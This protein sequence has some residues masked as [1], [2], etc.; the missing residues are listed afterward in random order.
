MLE[1]MFL[2]ALPSV[3]LAASQHESM[4]P[5]SGTVSDGFAGTPSGTPLSIRR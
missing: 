5:L 1:P 3:S 2:V 4:D